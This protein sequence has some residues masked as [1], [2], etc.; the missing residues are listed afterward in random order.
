MSEL[1]VGDEL[2]DALT[3]GLSAHGL[4]LVQVFDVA[5]Y[6]DLAASH[7]KLVPLQQF[8]RPGALALLIGNTKAL[9]PHFTRAFQT[10]PDLQQSTDP[11]DNWIESV[12][13]E[14]AG[15]IHLSH[16]LHFS[17]DTGEAF[18]SM[19]HLAEVSGL[20][21]RGP[22]HIGVH[23]EHGPWF[24]LR[25]LVIVDAEPPEAPLPSVDP[26]QGCAAPCVEA[27]ASALVVSGPDKI[28][29]AWEAWVHVR[30]VCPVGQTSRYGEDQIRYHYTKDVKALRL[31]E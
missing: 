5:R 27:L 29:S 23:A 4:D 11:L 15:K 3:S 19:L 1:K 30:D 21:H 7:E 14:C 24:G 6:N 25:A 31:T 18:I 9:W 20:A 26:C 13:R 22:A 10:S 17:H 28:A 12:V 2:A 16:V 8:G